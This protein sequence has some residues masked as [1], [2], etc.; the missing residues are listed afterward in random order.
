MSTV[1]SALQQSTLEA[2]RPLLEG[3]DLAILDF[4]NHSNCGD[5]AIWRGEVALAQALGC[6]VVY[7]CE[8]GT[9][10]RE[11]VAR[12]PS[13]TVVLLHG[14]G[15][16]G[17]LWPH[18]HAFRERVVQDFP[19]RRI[20]QMPQSIH[21]QDA[22]A[23]ERTRRII[24][25]HPDFVLVV[26]DHQSRRFAE[27]NFD[28]RVMLS[29]DMAFMLGALT[30]SAPPVQDVFTLARTDHEALGEAL[31]PVAAAEGL[32]PVDWGRP[33]PAA[34]TPEGFLIRVN[35][36]LARLPAP[37]RSLGLFERRHGWV[38]EHLAEG[39]V[40]RGLDFLGRGR[41][42]LTD[43]LHA[44]L[45]AELLGI[46]H[47]AVDSGYGKIRSYHETWL[48][49]SPLAH[50]ESDGRAGVRRARELVEELG[51]QPDVQGRR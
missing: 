16:F 37:L 49:D 50:L 33:R 44:H 45:L 13:S 25:Q 15:N 17:D 23:L 27:E 36:G 9:Y 2:F 18:F 6:R 19:D 34:H 42:V 24:D 26:R 1:I 11:D 51:R 20:V 22:K 31:G 4:P 35:L 38:Y 12:L 7:R 30:P 41:V 40:Q 8:T 10:R 3:R 29:P 5:S 43:R 39:H 32:Q 21:F 46:P 48:A 28:C 14:G 47:V